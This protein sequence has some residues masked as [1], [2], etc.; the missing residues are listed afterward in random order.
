MSGQYP[1]VQCGVVLSVAGLA[2]VATATH[3]N[4]TTVPPPPLGGGNTAV[5]PPAWPGLRSGSAISDS[6]GRNSR[7]C[8]S[9]IQIVHW[10]H[11]THPQYMDTPQ[12]V[13]TSPQCTSPS[14]HHHTNHLSD[15][16]LWFSQPLNQYTVDQC[17]DSVN[18]FQD[19]GYI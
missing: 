7:R 19:C 6:G 3:H 10:H 13:P 5:A 15:K 9:V 17:G 14:H 12:L 11:T 1:I 18:L 16:I 8:R 4:F 2:D